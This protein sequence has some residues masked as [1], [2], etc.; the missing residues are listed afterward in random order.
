VEVE[1]KLKIV[2]Q[3]RKIARVLI[4]GRNVNIEAAKE[5]HEIM[6]VLYCIYLN[7]CM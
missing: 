3:R 6:F 2:T 5:L 4:K 1:R 7:V